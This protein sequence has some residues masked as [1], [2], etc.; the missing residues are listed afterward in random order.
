MIGLDS[1]N[2]LVENKNKEFALQIQLKLQEYFIIPKTFT[3]NDDYV[4]LLAK[5][6]NI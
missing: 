1:Q 6:L 2:F 3:V 5:K 4:I